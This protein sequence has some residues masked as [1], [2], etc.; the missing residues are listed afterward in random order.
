M[1]SSDYVNFLQDLKANIP[2][3]P[4]AHSP[5]QYII[6]NELIS[7]DGLII[8]CGVET[9]VTTNYIAKNINSN[10]IVYGFDSFEGLPED[11]T[12]RPIKKR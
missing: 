6:E 8:G 11:W 1:M 2:K 3:I 7:S 12:P 9:A 5:L 10:R 4:N